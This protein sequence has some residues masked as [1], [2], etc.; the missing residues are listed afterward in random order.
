[1]IVK[2]FTG[3]FTT[4]ESNVPFFTYIYSTRLEAIAIRAEDI[5]IN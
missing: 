1:M 5:A 2:L 3:L 4:N